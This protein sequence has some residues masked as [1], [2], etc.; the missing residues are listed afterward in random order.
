[1]TAYATLTHRIERWRA[2][3]AAPECATAEVAFMLH[4]L[5]TGLASNELARQPPPIGVGYW[6]HV[7]NLDPKRLWRDALQALVDGLA[8]RAR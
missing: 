2:T 6:R 3:G 7:P 4:A 5:C 8:G 1:M